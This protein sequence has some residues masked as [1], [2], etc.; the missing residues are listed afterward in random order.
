LINIPLSE[1]SYLN[2]PLFNLQVGLASLTWFTRLSD[3]STWGLRT[4]AS[5]MHKKQG[6]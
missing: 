1:A 3:M 2:N 6:S 5:T 4:F